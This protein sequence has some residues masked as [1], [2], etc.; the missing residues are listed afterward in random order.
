MTCCRPLPPIPTPLYWLTGSPAARS[1]SSLPIG[2]PL[3]SPNSSLNADSSAS[4]T[5]VRH[6]VRT[7]SLEAEPSDLVGLI[8]GEVAFVPKPL[9]LVLVVTLPRQNV[10]RD[11]IKEPAVVGDHHSTPRKFQQRILQGLQGLDVKIVGRL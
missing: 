4:E 9:G 10:G 5:T 6:A 7:R 8:V 3:R 11:P 2:R 1:S